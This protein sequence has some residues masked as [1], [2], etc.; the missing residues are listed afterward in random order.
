MDL[1]LTEQELDEYTKLSS[2]VEKVLIRQLDKIWRIREG[3]PFNGEILFFY[4]ED[5]NIVIHTKDPVDKL[6]HVNVVNVENL[7]NDSR[8]EK[9]KEE[10]EE[11]KKQV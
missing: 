2:K 6:D 8:I 9:Y 1:F 5:E 11:Q 10:I 4:I 3:A 7:L